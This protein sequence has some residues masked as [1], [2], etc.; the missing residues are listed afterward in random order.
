MKGSDAVFEWNYS[1]N[2]KAADLKFIRWSVYNKT[3]K[4]YYPLAVEYPNGSVLFNPNIPP[5]YI[6]RVEKKGRATLVIRKISFEDST[7]F[8]CTLVGKN[9]ITD[10]WNV[11][12]LVVTG[13]V[14]FM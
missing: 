13:T 4:A 1:V 2:N 12:H 8:K 7:V 6:G 3:E 11:V 5:A 9:R 10:K 14:C